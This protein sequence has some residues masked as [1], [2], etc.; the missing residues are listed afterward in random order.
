MMRYGKAT[1][2]WRV[3]AP[4]LP[5]QWQDPIPLGC[6]L[7]VAA[8]LALARTGQVAAAVA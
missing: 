7:I 4:T 1:H 5:L 2:P 6:T 3:P 8:H